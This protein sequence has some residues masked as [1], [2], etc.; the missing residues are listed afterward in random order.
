MDCERALARLDRR[1]LRAYSTRT[2]ESLRG[3]VPLRVALPHLERFLARNV[4]K[5]IEKDE[6]V[7]RR[8]V[9]SANG[10]GTPGR[11]VLE[12]LFAE[13]QRIDRDFL[14]AAAGFP[15]D[16]VLRYEQI[17][18][19]RMRRIERLFESSARICEAR[20]SH[21]SLRGA[22]Q[23]CYAR[24][25]LERLVREILWLYSQEVLVLSRSVRL[26]ALIGPLREMV[27]QRL[28]R[29]MNEAASQL[30]GRAA[31]MVYR[32]APRAAARGV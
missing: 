4:A 31:R 19:V 25:E 21:G 7:I 26:P 6:R 23:A 24:P 30:A 20:R 1:I 14:S 32:V 28:V 13:T 11:D 22:L 2:T 5:E 9:Q 16:I 10:P 8:A 17:A 29:V 12:G 3:V 27:A 15:V 18:P